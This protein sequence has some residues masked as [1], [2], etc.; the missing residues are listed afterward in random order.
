[1]VLWSLLDLKQRPAGREDEALY[2][3]SLAHDDSR[4]SFEGTSLDYAAVHAILLASRVFM[5][6]G[7]RNGDGVIDE[8]YGHDCRISSL[9][10]SSPRIPPTSNCTAMVS[11]FAI[12]T[13]IGDWCICAR[14]QLLL[15]ITT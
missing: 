13:V 9:L 12:C 14:Y 10:C 6:G 4:G 2:W 7:N 5:S 1:L 8:K 15:V 11:C 3:M